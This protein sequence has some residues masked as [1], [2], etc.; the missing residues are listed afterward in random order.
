MGTGEILISIVNGRRLP[1]DPKT[2]LLVTAIDGRQKTVFRGFVNGGSVRMTDL[3]VNGNADDQFTILAAAKGQ[4]DA[5]F[6]PVKVAA[7]QSRGVE[8]MM[9]PREAAF[10]FDPFSAIETLPRRADLFAFMCGLSSAAAARS[11]YERLSSQEQGK[12]ALACLLN[13]A[14]ALEQMTLVGIEATAETPAFELNPLKAF[15]AL[16]PARPLEQDRFFAWVDRRLPEQIEKTA[17]NK[18]VGALSR[19]VTAPAALHPGATASFKQIDFG[20]GNVQFSI[21]GEAKE[22]DGLPC[23]LVEVDV[24]YFKDPGAHLLLEV[25]PNTLKE[26]VHGKDSAAALTDPRKVYGLRWVAGRR[27]GRE[28]NPPYV[29]Q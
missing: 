1:L 21:H 13:I 18:G 2:R 16:E 4:S 29:L 12:P 25:F 7:G 6:S 15:K 23:I 22:I 10:T 19:F 20:E 9:L 24:D 5:G 11:R 26:K 28:F 3:A 27:L 8:L 17:A 14:S